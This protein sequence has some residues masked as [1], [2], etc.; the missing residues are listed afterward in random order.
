MDVTKAQIARGVATFIQ[1][2]MITGIGDNAMQIILGIAAGAITSNPNIMDGVLKN[3]LFR[4]VAGSGE[5][6]DFSVIKSAATAAIDRYGKLTVT[7]PG[8]KFISPDDKILQFGS[9]DINR[10]MARIE[11]RQLQ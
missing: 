8:I 9:D 5:N 11:G 10:L 1:E 3:E 2:D 7:I 6:Y 4:A